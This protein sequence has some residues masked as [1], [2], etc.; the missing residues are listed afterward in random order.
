MKQWAIQEWRL[1]RS[2]LLYRTKQTNQISE[3]GS[4]CSKESGNRD[5]K[6]VLSTQ[7]KDS[8]MFWTTMCH[9]QREFEHVTQDGWAD[10]LENL[11]WERD[12]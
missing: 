9:V 6:N 11:L 7:K 12:T 8:E 10:M 4:N 2:L 5:L 1:N 3:M